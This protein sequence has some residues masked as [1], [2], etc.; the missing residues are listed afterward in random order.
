[1]S[2]SSV[3]DYSNLLSETLK[4]SEEVVKLGDSKVWPTACFL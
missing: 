2:L 1:M 4:F 3:L